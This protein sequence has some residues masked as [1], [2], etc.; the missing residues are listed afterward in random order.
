MQI[1]PFHLRREMSRHHILLKFRQSQVL[2]ETKISTKHDLF[3]YLCNMSPR[4]SHN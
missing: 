3:P 2:G 1:L 4:V